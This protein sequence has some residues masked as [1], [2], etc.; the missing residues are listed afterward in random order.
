MSIGRNSRPQNKGLGNLSVGNAKFPLSGST[1]G[2]PLAILDSSTGLGYTEVHKFSLG[3]VEELYLW[4]SNRGA[5]AAN[6]TMSFG[7]SGF[8]GETIIVEVNAS[9]GL[10]L[11]YPGILHQGDVDG[12]QILYARASAA[13]SLNVSGFV[14]RNYPFAGKDASVYGF[15]NSESE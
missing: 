9:Q 1:N 10:S 12:S 5:S 7:D 6:L 4:C 2:N 15:F 11:V 3:V 8:S 13:N 14:I